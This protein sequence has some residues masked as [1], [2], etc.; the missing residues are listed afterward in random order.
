MM[1]MFA[2]LNPWYYFTSVYYIKFLWVFSQRCIIVSFLHFLYSRQS[3]T[4]SK[5]QSF[6]ETA[7]R[8][9]YCS[10]SLSLSGFSKCPKYIPFPPGSG[11]DEV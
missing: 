1:V 2:F 4:R 6:V 11:E 5:P 3:D 7:H 8:L 9:M 10:F